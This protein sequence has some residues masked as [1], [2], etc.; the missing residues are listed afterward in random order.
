MEIRKYEKIDFAEVAELFYSTVHS[1]NLKDYSQKQVDAWATGK[2]DS[3]KWNKSLLENYSIVAIEGKKIIGFGDINKTNY[4]DRLYVHK[5]FQ[6][7]GVAT[8]ICD[9]LEKQ[10]NGDTIAVHASITAK[11]F[12]EKRGYKVLKEQ[13]VELA[14]VFLIN[15]VMEK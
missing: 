11:P 10:A 3:D 15:Y 12:F 13:N 5:D 8:A 9:E 6:G 14:G 7:R 1:V 4:L 2:L